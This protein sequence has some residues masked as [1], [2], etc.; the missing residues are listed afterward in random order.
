MTMQTTMQ[1]SAINRFMLSGPAFEMDDARETESPKPA[2]SLAIPAI[3]THDQ[4]ASFDARRFILGGNAT[5]TLEGREQ[6][7]TY[8]VTRSDDGAVYFVALL[9]GPDNTAD[10]TYLGLLDDA[11]GA[12]RLT[13]KSRMTDDSVPVIALRWALRWIWSGKPLPAPAKIYHV[14][15]CGR[16]GRALTVPSSIESGFG[17]ECLGKIG[18]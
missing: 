14:G 2:E 10:Y 18:A 13:R 11:S 5:F 1:S 8:R 4:N 12:V 17:P 3:S 9:T 6:R 7:Y 16:C 15:R